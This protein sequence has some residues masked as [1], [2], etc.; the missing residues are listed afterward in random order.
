MFRPLALG[1]LMAVVLAGIALRDWSAAAPADVGSVAIETPAH[2]AEAGWPQLFGPQLNSVSAERGLIADFP[3]AGPPVLWRRPLGTG[4]SAPVAVD[5]ACYVLFRRGDEEVLACIGLAAGELIWEQTRPTRFVCKFERYSSGPYSTPVIDGDC[6]YTVGAEARLRCCDRRT[7]EPIWE[8]QLGEE[9]EPPPSLFGFGAGMLI[10][11]ERLYLNL[12]AAAKQAG[13]IALDKR[14]G[15]LLWQSTDYKSA[16][17]T[18]RLIGA[19]DARRLLVLTQTGLVA[20]DPRDGA[21]R[22]FFEFHPRSVDT[23]NAVTPVVA[24]DLVLLVS[25]PGPGAVCLRLTPDDE[26]K[27]VWRNRRTLDSQFNAVVAHGGFV[28]GFTSSK[29]GGA[30]LRC[31][32]LAT[33]TIRWSHASDLDRG[34]TL[35]A[36]G[37]LLALGEQGHLAMFELNPHAA[38]VRAMSAEPLLAAPCFSQPALHRGR[39]LVRNEREL[40]CFDLR[41]K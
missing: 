31:V 36:D 39:L 34:Q 18:P 17:T 1:I 38:V 28:Y 13:V 33:G 21:E 14:D 5:D 40:V 26:W 8:R 19:G 10:D 27:T 11:D 25:G 29:Q 6:I 23:I 30:E 41:A 4:Y 32:E 15:A 35:A 16:Y 37:K 2:T 22:A 24:S 20:L 7:G 12:G 9:F 3:V